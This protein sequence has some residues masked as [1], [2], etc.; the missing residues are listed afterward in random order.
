MPVT[1][2]VNMQQPIRLLL[3]DTVELDGGLIARELRQANIAHSLRRVEGATAS[4]DVLADGK[5]DIIICAYV[6]PGSNVRDVLRMRA[7]MGKD[8]PL[9]VVS[10]AARIADAVELLRS[11]VEEFIEKDD[12]S[13]LAPAIQRT[14]RAAEAQRLRLRA[15]EQATRARK[16]EAIGQLTGGIAHDFNNYLA[17]I[18]GN[19]EL[20]DDDLPPG[21]P[22]KRFLEAA[23]AAT[24][25]GAELTRGLLAFAC[26]QPIHPRVTKIGN[27]IAATVQLLERTLGENIRIRVANPVNAWPVLVDDGLLSACLL[28]LANNARDAMRAGGTLAI[29]VRNIELDHDASRA[30]P[31]LA[32]GDYVLLEVADT[33]SGMPAEALQR[34]FEP[35]FSTKRAAQRTGLG[36][37]MVYG[38]VKQSSGH[39]KLDSVV[40]H[41]TTV[42]IYLPRADAEPVPQALG[43]V[44]RRKAP[45]GSETILVVEDRASLRHTVAAQLADLGYRVEEA[46]DGD[47]ALALLE[48]DEPRIDLLFTD[49]IMPGHLD[50]HALARLAVERHP[51]IKVLLT[52]GFDGGPLASQG[53]EPPEYS[54]LAKPYRK[55]DLAWAVRAALDTSPTASALS[56]QPKAPV[57][58]AS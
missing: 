42:R 7:E 22:A 39:I 30:E 1:I 33:G 56:S 44:A 55:D 41:G 28:N 45:I 58:Q 18:L 34:A 2:G 15:E 26:Q 27:C 12:L 40:G 32:P 36:L 6:S 13:R 11:G 49:I 17:I 48:Q 21:I 43:I 54:L 52:T 53:G 57:A 10:Q 5:F 50:G 4:R 38:F 51:G 24:L 46:S 19:L 25:Q 29:T 23:L 31:E 14:L 16:M 47:A 9:I 35:F 8:I 3:I 37:S 20:L